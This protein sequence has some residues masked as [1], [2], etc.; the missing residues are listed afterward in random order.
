MFSSSMSTLCD[1]TMEDTLLT[2]RNYEAAR[3]EYDANRFDL[4]TLQTTLN[5]NNNNNEQKTHQ[6]IEIIEKDIEIYHQ[7]YNQLKSDVKIKLKFLDENRVKV[8]KKQL[9]LFHKAIV[10]YYSGNAQSLEGTIQ[11]I[12]S[13]LKS[14]NTNGYPDSHS[15]GSGSSSDELTSTRGNNKQLKIQ[16]FLE[17]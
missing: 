15:N 7:K 12:E 1:K 11:R 17:E 14:I 2:I 6:Q 8:M 5:N 10:A 9:V 13:E 16:S 3:L 4:E